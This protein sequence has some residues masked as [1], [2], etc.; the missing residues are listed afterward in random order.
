[1]NRNARYPSPTL[2]PALAL[3]ACLVGS[4]AFAATEATMDQAVLGIQHQWEQAIYQTPEAARGAALTKLDSEAKAIAAHYPG[5][6][7]P[8][9]WEAIS[10][11]SHAK[12]EGG[13]TGLGMA[14]QARDLLEQA[15]QID[16]KALNGS[17]YSSLGAL[18]AKVP[19]WPL[20]FGDKDKAETNFKKALAINPDG[21]DPNYL[22]ADFLFDQQRYPEAKAA[23]ERAAKAPPRTNRPLA[24]Q[25][26]GREVQALLTQ[27]RA[28]LDSGPSK[29]GG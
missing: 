27:V 13:L 23:L 12:V 2:A 3:A 26:R 25:G 28:K 29:A 7:E 20:G 9:I 17:A 6:A 11:S 5:R 16:P 18:Y 1:M 4:P 10:L 19:G 14:K 8:L 24:D 15:A 21:I 22:Y